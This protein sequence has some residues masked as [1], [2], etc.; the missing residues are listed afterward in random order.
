MQH[1]WFRSYGLKEVRV[2]GTDRD[3]NQ[4]GLGN[5]ILSQ[6]YNLPKGEAHDAPFEIKLEDE[7]PVTT[8][9]LVFTGTGG[10]LGLNEVEFFG[11]IVKEKAK[12]TQKLNVLA[13]N[14]RAELRVYRHGAYYVLENKY[15]IYAV[16]PRYGGALSFAWDKQTKSNLIRFAEVGSSYG[17]LFQDRFHPGGSEN[18][19]MYLYREY[20]AEIL[21]DTPD[22]KQVRVWGTGHSGIFTSVEISKTYTLTRDSSVIGV[23]ITITNGKDNVIPLKY[24][25]WMAGGLHSDTEPYSRIIPGQTSTEVRPGVGEFTSMDFVSGWCGGMV[26]GNCLAILFPYEYSREIYYWGADKYNGTIETRFGVYPIEAGG[27]LTYHCAV[28]PFGGIG[29][30]DKVTE[31]AACAIVDDAISLRL[32][33]S[34]TYSLRIME[35]EEKDGKGVF[36]QAAMVELPPNETGA[37]VPFKRTRPLLRVELLQGGETVF[38][39]EKSNGEYILPQDCPRKPSSEGG[40]AKLNLDFHSD[41]FKTDA[42]NWGGKFANGKPKVLF[43]NNLHGG[44]R[45]A[46]ELS[47]RFEID[48]TTNYVAGFWSLSGHCMSLNTRTCFNELGKKL[49]K[50]YDVIIVSADIWAEL[51]DNVLKPLLAQVR[52]G[53]GLI[54]VGAEALPQELSELFPQ[55]DKAKFRFRATWSDSDHPLASS[56]PLAQMP[57]TRFLRYQLTDGVIAKSG[58]IPVIAEAKLGKGRVFLCAWETKKPNP[59]HSKYNASSSFLLP[60][61]YKEHPEITH[62]YYE[63]QYALLGRLVQA[64]AGLE[65]GVKAKIEASQTK[66][67][68]AVVAAEPQDVVVR[69]TLRDKFSQVIEHQEKAVR[70][71]KGRG[72]EIVFNYAKPAMTGTFFADVVVLRKDGAGALWWGAG[73]AVNDTPAITKLEFP[74]KV[75]R[76]NESVTGHAEGIGTVTAELSDTYGNVVARMEGNDFTLPLAD[77]RTP[78]ARLTVRLH[79]GTG[80]V[81]DQC[82]RRIELYSPP[83]PRI[84]NIVLGWPG[85][86]EKA[87]VYLLDDLLGIAKDVYGVTV[88]SATDSYTEASFAM[89]AIRD[90]ALRY[91]NINGATYTDGKYPFD[92]DKK[93][94]SKFDLIRIP[95]LSKPG[96]EERLFKDAHRPGWAAKYGATNVGG[97]D[98]SSM[99]SGFDGCFC[100]DC[101]KALREYL[102]T[103]YPT[104]DALNK[105]WETSFASWDTVVARTA[106][107]IRADGSKSFAT[108]VDHRT[109]NDISRARCIGI[110]QRGIHDMDATLGYSLSGTSETNPWNAWDWYLLMD[111]LY[112]FSSYIGEQ[113]IQQLS[114]AKRPIRNMP[115]SG[116]DKDPDMEDYCM[117]NNLMFGAAGLSIYGCNFYFCPDW[118]IPETGIGLRNVIR[119]Y[120]NGPAELIMAS[121]F[122]FDPI[123]FHYSPASIKV[124]WITDT[125]LMRNASITGFKGLFQDAGCNNSYIA[126]GELEKRQLKGNRIIVLP[127]SQALSDAEIDCLDAFVRDGGILLAD[128]MPGTYDQHGMPRSNTTLLNLFGIKKQG[129]LS[130]GETTLSGLDGS[131]KDLN[132]TINVYEQGVEASTAKPLAHVRGNA[133]AVLV[134]SHGKGKT[135][136]FACNLVARCGELGA[137]RKSA[138][139]AAMIEPIGR[140]I[141]SLLDETAIQPEATVNL[142]ATKVIVR[143]LGAGKIIGVIRDIS[144]TKNFDTMPHDVPVVLRE[145]AHVYD[146]LEHK[147][148]GY[149]DKFDYH[150]I[151]TTQ[152]AF[153]LLPYRATGLTAT[154]KDGAVRIS[155]DA[156]GDAPRINHIFQTAFIAPDGTESP[157]Y[158]GLVFGKGTSAVVP[159]KKPL[160]KSAK[161]WSVRITDAATNVSTMLKLDE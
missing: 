139:N 120:T 95:C 24:G 36:T 7:T 161:G 131:L 86:A 30:P 105:A 109:F 130:T 148:I 157:A 82:V 23:D 29:I 111:E 97:P 104:L 118:T 6:P 42:W 93:I 102:K 45:E 147:Y 154:Y 13:E 15:S 134:N 124:D 65:T 121:S 156:E 79:D 77:V 3:G 143:R 92:K 10:Y 22:V 126:Y 127:M 89:N 11:E 17:P 107:E 132:M 81:T 91:H 2:V 50:V 141:G 60:L 149:T 20:K 128:M 52:N 58:D 100:E 87:P 25:Y 28:A 54:L 46:V 85:F 115:W 113:T 140:F 133:P 33:K 99:I 32:F 61:V 76:L 57:Q 159:F 51:P 34:G 142:A 47:R 26:G 103:Q 114:F 69:L 68:V 67:T 43:I 112:A 16:D 136:Y 71:E 158:S 138:K 62:R 1:R 144:Q 116:Y 153:I 70:L 117:L 48:L 49:K 84:F 94:N 88:A 37:T 74:A 31:T 39:A 119:R 78:N 151:S 110:I 4:V 44:I 83:D 125:A 66:A 21:K 145:K 64:A 35:G 18:R 135:V 123:A 137:L 55:A 19:D 101:Q 129:S 12:S 75:Y 80:G 72:Q 152:S 98:E 73:T 106:A 160:N 14:A 5:I 8:V 38:W 56:L 122:A 9:Q 41:S 150:F 90:N 53:A 108:W 27:S 40:E 59:Q 63:Y 146:L 155:L 96:M